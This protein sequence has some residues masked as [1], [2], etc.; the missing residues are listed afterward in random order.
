MIRVQNLYNLQ[1][2]VGENVQKPV[3][4]KIHCHIAALLEKMEENFSEAIMYNN[5]LSKKYI[6]SDSGIVCL[7]ERVLS[8]IEKIYN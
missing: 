6:N 5:S 4:I 8:R 2:Y 3:D 7:K 1:E